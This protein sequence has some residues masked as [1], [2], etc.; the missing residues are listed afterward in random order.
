MKTVQ[1]IKHY[2]AKYQKGVSEAEIFISLSKFT[3]DGFKIAQMMR[4]IT[5]K[6]FILN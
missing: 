2:K 4:T 6:K 5:G 3:V 1:I